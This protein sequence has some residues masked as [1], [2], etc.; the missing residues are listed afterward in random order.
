[1]AKDLAN[2]FSSP[3]NKKY[4][5]MISKKLVAPGQEDLSPK[6]HFQKLLMVPLQHQP[7][8]LTLATMHSFF[9][10]KMGVSTFG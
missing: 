10:Q 6:H 3:I 7:I 2:T 8:K 9:T 5:L 1:L 4:L